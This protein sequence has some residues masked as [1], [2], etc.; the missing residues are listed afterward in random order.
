[1]ILAGGKRW[2]FKETIS[3]LSDGSGT[4]I[5]CSLFARIL[6]RTFSKAI[7]IFFRLPVPVLGLLGNS[8]RLKSE[9]R[10]IPEFLQYS[11]IF[12]I[13]LWIGPRL[14]PKC[15]EREIRFSSHSSAYPRRNSAP[16]FIR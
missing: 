5:N 3:L 7:E 6:Y 15:S 4:G 14:D 11:R 8:K 9:I 1:M 2:L 16:L 10:L 13:F 12:D